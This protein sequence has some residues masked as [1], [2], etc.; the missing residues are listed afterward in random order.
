VRAKGEYVP[1]KFGGAG[2]LS[3]GR[4]RSLGRDEETPESLN[5]D[6]KETRWTGVGAEITTSSPA[7][8]CADGEAAGDDIDCEPRLPSVVRRWLLGDDD[9]P[10][11]SGVL[12]VPDTLAL[13]RRSLAVC[14]AAFSSPR[15][16]CCL[17]SWSRLSRSS[18]VSTWR[19]STRRPGTVVAGLVVLGGRG[20]GGVRAPC[21]LDSPLDDEASGEEVPLPLLLELL[22]TPDPD[23]LR[24]MVAAGEPTLPADGVRADG[25]ARA[26]HRHISRRVWTSSRRAS[27]SVFHCSFS[28]L[29]RVISL[30][31][32]KQKHRP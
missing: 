20:G 30:C 17:L 21:C 28:S 29:S 22:R 6:E 7:P 16:T 32:D 12:D 26:P 25:E 15:G 4:E 8:R 5:P 23:E 27:A 13:C 9:V 31:V 14:S 3:G 1:F 10:A 2:G 24:G 18:R 11:A 19:S